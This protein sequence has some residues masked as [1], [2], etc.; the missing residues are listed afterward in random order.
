MKVREEALEMGKT[1]SQQSS[2]SSFLL[3]VFFLQNFFAAVRIPRLFK[4]QRF[5]AFYL[6]L[7]TMG[8]TEKVKLCLLHP[9]LAALA[10]FNKFIHSQLG[11]ALD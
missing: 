7:I 11:K 8:L 6:G 1:S 3:A 10:A 5:C 2:F 4:S 9:V